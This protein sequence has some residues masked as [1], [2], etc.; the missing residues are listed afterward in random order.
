[1]RFSSVHRPSQRSLVNRTEDFGGS[2]VLEKVTDE[3]DPKTF[4]EAMKS[5]DV[6]FWKEAI[7]DEMDFI[8]GNN[9]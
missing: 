2:L 8:M 1:N 4:D 6:A 5:Q 7:T 3:D 9:T